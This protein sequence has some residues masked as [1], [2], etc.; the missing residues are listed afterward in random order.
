[1]PNEYVHTLGFENVKLNFRKNYKI[2]EIKI[3]DVAT[4]NML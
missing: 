2:V 4:L 1:M 3:C